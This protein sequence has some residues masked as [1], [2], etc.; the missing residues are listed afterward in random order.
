MHA[1]IQHPSGWAFH[2]GDVPGWVPPQTPFTPGE[3]PAGSQAPDGSWRPPGFFPPNA[4][5]PAPSSSGTGLLVLAVLALGA[6]VA[7]KAIAHPPRKRS[8]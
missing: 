3:P 5:E 8:L 6:L 7:Y 4:F 1:A 2:V